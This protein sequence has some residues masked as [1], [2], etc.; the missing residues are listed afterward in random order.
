MNL[1][2]GWGVETAKSDKT[3]C[4]SGKYR[5]GATTV[6]YGSTKKCSTCPTGFGSS[7]AG[8]T[9]NTQCYFVVDAGKHKT[10]LTTATTDN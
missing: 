6:N 8:A 10:A 9:K 4:T 1:A 2:E 7:V 3:K 5:S